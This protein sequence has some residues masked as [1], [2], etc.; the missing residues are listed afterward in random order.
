MSVIRK[1]ALSAAALFISLSALF[2]G[3]GTATAATTAA[4]TLSVDCEDDWHTPCP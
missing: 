3:V 4:P 1:L 2:V